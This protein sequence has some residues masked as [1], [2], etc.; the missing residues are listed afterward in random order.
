M[1]SM[2][3]LCQLYCVLVSIMLFRNRYCIITSAY[4][5][6][7]PLNSIVVVTMV[8]TY[9]YLLIIM[10]HDEKNYSHYLACCCG[11]QSTRTDHRIMTHH[12]DRKNWQL[13]E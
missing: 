13:M 7:Q 8:V 2:S 5:Q 1:T 12:H 6:S 3:R 9:Y 10:S 11:P 4:G